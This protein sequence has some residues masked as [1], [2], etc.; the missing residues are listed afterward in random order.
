MTSD[1]PYR[2]ALSKRQALEE[3]RACAGTQFDPDVVRIFCQTLN[4]PHVESDRGIQPNAA[5]AAQT[6]A[7]KP[8]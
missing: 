4:T 3:L 6:E 7:E 2:N 8:I 1:R 5:R